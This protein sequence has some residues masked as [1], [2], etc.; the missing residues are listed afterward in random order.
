MIFRFSGSLAFVS[1][2]ALRW[3][4]SVCSFA[5]EVARSSFAFATLPISGSTRNTTS[6]TAPMIANRGARWLSTRG[7]RSGRAA[8]G[9]GVLGEVDRR[10]ELVGPR[11]RRVG[12]DVRG[13]RVR[14][15]LNITQPVQPRAV[16]FEVQGD[17]RERHRAHERRGR[18]AGA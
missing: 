12:G 8:L 5:A 16:L 10:V 17:P 13:P 3:T 2:R 1:S 15:S 4:V 18:R 14:P 9:Q 11:D 7:L 6:T